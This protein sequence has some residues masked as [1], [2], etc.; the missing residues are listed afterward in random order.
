MN[1]RIKPLPHW[2]LTNLQ[3]AFYDIESVTSIEMVAKLYG[4]MQNLVSDYN[5]FVDE[6]NMYIDEFEKGII[7][8]FEDFKECIIKTMNDYIETVDTKIN[9][10]DLKI[11]NTIEYIKDHI[12]ETVDTLFQELIDND[13]IEVS[14][15]EDYDD[16][17]ENLVLS[18]ELIINQN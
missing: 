3:P 4:K 12:E 7:K 18:A 13:E 9:L 15:T 16:I 1:T 11:D 17:N 8:D 5:K 6:L 14:L 2:A 10:Q